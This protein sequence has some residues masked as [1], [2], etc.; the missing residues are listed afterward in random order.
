MFCTIRILKNEVSQLPIHRYYLAGIGYKKAPPCNRAK[1]YV[2]KPPV[3]TYFPR[4]HFAKQSFCL[5]TILHKQK[6]PWQNFSETVLPSGFPM[7]VIW[8]PITPKLRPKLLVSFRFSCSEVIFPAIL[9]VPV[10]HRHR[11]ALPFR[12]QLLSSSLHFI[13]YFP[14]FYDTLSEVCISLPVKGALLCAANGLQGS[15]NSSCNIIY[16]R[17]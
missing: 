17:L 1:P 5:I 7:G 16:R 11:L 2:R 15:Q 3:T 8:F 14:I 6:S 4:Q 9:L 12:G 13:F 10:F